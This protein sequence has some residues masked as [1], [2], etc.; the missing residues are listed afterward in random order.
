MKKLLEDIF[1]SKYL[2]IPIRKGIESLGIA[3][4]THNEVLV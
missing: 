3:R 4:T 2:F 1:S